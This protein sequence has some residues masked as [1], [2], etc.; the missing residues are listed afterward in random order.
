MI[1]EEIIE[2][3]N[4]NEKDFLKITSFSKFPGIYAI[5]YIGENFPLLGSSVSKHQIIYIGKTET[6]QEDRDAKT[7][8]VSGKTGS[9]TVRK[10]I[11]SILYESKKLIPI[12][13][14]DKDFDS[15]RFSHFKFNDESEEIITEWMKNNLALAFYEYPKSKAEIENLEADLIDFLVP[16][17]NISKNQKNKFKN[18]LQTLRKECAELAHQLTCER[19]YDTK[20]AKP[21]KNQSS[22]PIQSIS[23]IGSIIIDNITES[24]ILVGN[25][26]IK[27]ENKYFFPSEQIGQ[28]KIYNLNC[29]VNNYNFI[30][31]YK[32]GSKDSK[33]RSGIL[34]IGNHVYKD[35]LKI[36]NKTNLKIT[37]TK[38]NIYLMETL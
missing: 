20:M 37:K 22:N 11:G 29:R 34:K 1:L 3:L 35:L 25:I 17:L 26:R 6:S 31:Q 2:H 15:G 5:F 27:V 9:S 32:I 12:P 33:A 8:F 13:R 21:I 19:N 23:N 4:N 36:H 7:H 28:P 30:S 38:E 18:S 10:S 16:I 24:D 14:N